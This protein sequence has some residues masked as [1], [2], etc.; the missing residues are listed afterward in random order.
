MNLPYF[1]LRWAAEFR[2]IFTDLPDH[3]LYS[4]VAR[5]IPPPRLILLCANHMQVQAMQQK[6]Q[7][8]PV[9]SLWT[10]GIVGKHFLPGKEKP[11]PIGSDYLSLLSAFRNKSGK[12][13]ASF[14][15]RSS[16]DGYQRSGKGRGSS[17][18]F[19]RSGKGGYGKQG[20]SFS[21]GGK[22]SFD[23][24]RKGNGGGRGKSEFRPGRGGRSG[25]AGK[26]GKR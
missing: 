25:Y 14:E 17:D 9:H 13:G 8:P 4:N 6:M 20:G 5:Q 3:P 1:L 2:L 22:S 26:G 18:G 11:E 23:K 19:Q 10:G 12:R 7:I 15:G 24:G 16:S 21:K